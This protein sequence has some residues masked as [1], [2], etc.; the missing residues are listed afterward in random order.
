MET[1]GVRRGRSLL[2]LI[3]LGVLWRP[4]LH[5]GRSGGGRFFDCRALQWRLVG[6]VSRGPGARR[7]GI[8]GDSHHFYFGAVDGGV[9]A[10]EDAGRTW[11]PIFDSEPA[12]RS[13]RWRWRRRRLPPSTWAPAKRTCAPKSPTAR[14]CTN[15]SMRANTGPSRLA[16]TRQIAASWSIAR[17]EVSSSL[18][19]DMPMARMPTVACSA[20]RMAARTG[21][22]SC[23]RIADTGAI[24]LAFK[25]GAAA[26]PFTRRCGR[27]GVRPGASIRRRTVLGAASM[28]PTTAAIIGVR[29]LG[30]GFPAHPGRTD[31]PWRRVSRNGSMRSSMPREKEGGLY[32]SDDGGVHW[33]HVSA[34]SRIFSRG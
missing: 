30:N 33:N 32:R 24:D 25:P 26:I 18:P 27:R 21:A 9:W 3:R 16:D 23:S 19:W 10:T 2:A 14:A 34:D 17:S 15:P 28:C 20:R 29:S 8:A 1:A 4:G 5:C 7:D 12:A 31:S 6:P 13:V 22:R 11:Q